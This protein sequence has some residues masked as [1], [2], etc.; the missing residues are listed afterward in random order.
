MRILYNISIYLFY[1]IIL[2]VSIFNKK[3]SLWLKGRKGLFNKLKA[4][5]K[6]GENIVWFHCSSLGEFEQGRPVIEAF[7]KKY[8]HYKILLTFFSPS[9]YE[10]RKNYNGA[11]YIFY[12]P[13]D[14]IANAKKFINIIKPEMAFFIK[15]EYWYNYLNILHKNSI[16]VYLISAI[17]RPKQHFFRWYGVW[18]RNHLKNIK[19]IFV[20]NEVSEALLNSI[21]IEQ[22]TVSG[23]TRFDRVYAI[24]QENK[25]LPVIEQFIH[26]NKILVAGS[27]WEKDEDIIKDLFLQYPDK[28]KLIIAPHLVNKAHINELIWKFGNVQIKYSE[29]IQRCET[30]DIRQKT[31]V[32]YNIFKDKRVLIID[33][34]GILPHL[35]KYCDI[36]YVGGGFGSGIHN[37]LE[38]AVYGKP[39]IFGPNYQKF[40][41]AKDLTDIGGAFCIRNNTDLNMLAEKLLND[42]TYRNKTSEICKNYVKLKTGATEAIINKIGKS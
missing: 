30:Q 32:S 5:I 15:Y 39:V 14:T 2:I 40:W 28:L 19:H 1:L 3:A 24:A 10:I 25:S 33:S 18:F 7:I 34:I 29:A 35:Y 4:T 42:E 11:D 38:A 17:Y 8:P 21:G 16:P 12:L 22:V 20:Q 36:G 13:V 6:S 37:I 31:D 41:E 9:G 23:D 26:D 27:T